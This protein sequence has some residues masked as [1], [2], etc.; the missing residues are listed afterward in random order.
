MVHRQPNAAIK[1]APAAN[2]P[3]N[4]AWSASAEFEWISRAGECRQLVAWR[5]DLARNAGMRRATCIK[6]SGTASF[7]GAP[8]VSAETAAAVGRFLFE[9]DPAVLA[10]KLTGAIAAR[11]GVAA[12]APG[13]AYFTGCKWLDD[14]LLVAFEVLDRLPFDVRTVS[15]YLRQRSVGRIEI[16]HRGLTIDPDGLRR[17]LKL[18][19]SEGATVIITKIAGH[20]AVFVVQR[21]QERG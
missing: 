12:I 1:L 19:G 10:A 16:K 2:L 20:A 13:V 7:V 9:P 15:A 3:A 21:V 4:R 6:K 18:R 14:P 11:H 8:D 5:G 17:Q